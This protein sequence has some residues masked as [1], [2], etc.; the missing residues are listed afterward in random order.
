MSMEECTCI[1][2]VFLKNFGN[3]KNVDI[4]RRDVILGLGTRTR[5]QMSKARGSIPLK[6][7]IATAF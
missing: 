2:G 5:V 4:L 3:F 6:R 1:N 7:G